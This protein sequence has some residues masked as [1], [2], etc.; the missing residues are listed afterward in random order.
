MAEK[1]GWN[2]LCPCG[3]G[4]KYKKCCGRDERLAELEKDAL[5]AE[6]KKEALKK[7]TADKNAVEKNAA[8]LD[9]LGKY[10]AKGI[11]DK[12][13]ENFEKGEINS[14]DTDA[15]TPRD[16]ES[17]DDFFNSIS[18]SDVLKALL[19]MQT[20]ILDRKPHI[21]KYKKIRK[22]HGEV[23]GG[24]MDYYH[25][26][27]FEQKIDLEYVKQ[28]HADAKTDG[29]GNVTLFESRFDPNTDEGMEGMAEMLVYKKSPNVSC[30]TED[31]INSNRY[32]KP[33]KIEFLYSM[34]NS[35]LSL[36]E[37]TDA[38]PVEGYVYLKDVYTGEEYKITDVSL[39]LYPV[40]NDIYIYRRIITYDG[41]CFGT[42]L[43]S[44]FKK[45]DSF[46]KKHI[47]HHKKNYQPHGEYIRFIQLYNEYT[48][49]P[50]RIHTQ[51]N[52]M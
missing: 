29:V 21:K 13:I 25:K 50:D 26:G 15:H 36:F 18:S 19:G 12:R 3:S 9:F 41:V 40:E 6:I 7:D 28:V 22:L 49:N 2:R 52:R 34:L 37:I 4:R 30:I 16:Y 23:L 43:N 38:E 1:T 10:A 5:E 47:A 31:F 51:R 45:S 35:R 11:H 24:M 39:S 20:L 48:N 8:N 44:V 27:K 42:G 32:R 14:P 17:V 46:I 33:E